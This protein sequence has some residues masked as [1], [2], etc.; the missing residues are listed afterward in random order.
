MEERCH[1]VEQE[2]E[3]L[4][5]ESSRCMFQLEEQLADALQERDALLADLASEKAACIK[6][7]EVC[8]YTNHAVQD[9]ALAEAPHSQF[10]EIY[11]CTCI[12]MALTRKCA[13]YIHW[14]LCLSC[15]RGLCFPL[16]YIGGHVAR[17][18]AP[19]RTSRPAGCQRF[20]RQKR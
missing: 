5:D 18:G 12:N 14:P 19:H 8:P 3:A 13:P 6:K 2:F 7:H 9:S 15:A 1:S 17:Q 4:K 16:A 10:L 11:A 20:L